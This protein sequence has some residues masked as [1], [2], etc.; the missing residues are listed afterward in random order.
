MLANAQRPAFV[1]GAQA[2]RDNAWHE[3]IALAERHRAPVWA[4]PMSG[5]NAFPEN[6]PLFAGFLPANR[7][8]IVEAL[9]GHD[10]VLVIG[11]PAF[12]Y[13]V[14]GEGPFLPSGTT[15]IQLTD[16]PNMAAWT[17]A[18]T[19]IV[20]GLKLGV[21]ALLAG[22]APIDRATPRKRTHAPRLSGERL[23]DAYLMQQIAAL[24][25]MGSVIVEEAPSTRGPMHDYLPITDEHGFYT[26]SSGGLGHGLPASVGVALGRPGTRVIAI[27][28]DG[29]AMYSVQALWSAAQLGLPITFVI[30]K[31]GAYR[32]LD[33][34]AP[35]FG[36][37]RAV[38]T[39]LP[40]L[41]FTALAQGHG[42]RAM[43][44]A[45]AD[46][47]DMALKTAFQSPSPVLVEV[48]IAS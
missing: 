29:S 20:A 9:D 42:V 1:V 12:T 25:P 5:R 27:L 41:D 11:A 4:A 28:G 22:P 39:A 15:L 32:A 2:A 6:H 18:G 31:N 47:L 26:C 44:A 30:V 23:T 36:V 21:D 16:D 13:H 37:E 46:E 10:L 19:S 43:R 38:G 3:T 33:D 35:H 40:A 48:E 17:P 24:R 8:G 34:F 7:A 45:Q 14:E